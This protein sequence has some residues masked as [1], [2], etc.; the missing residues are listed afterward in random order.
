[1]VRPWITLL[2]LGGLCQAAFAQRPPAQVPASPEAVIERLP[3]GYSALRS[4]TTATQGTRSNPII[5][6][7]QLLQAAGRTGD[8]R[9]AARADVLLAGIPEQRR[10]ARVRKAQAFSAQHR[11]EFALSLQLLDAVI[12]DEPRDPDARLARAQLHL[13]QGRIRAARADCAALAFSVDSQSGTAC[14]AALSLRTGAL[15]NAAT[16]ADL[17]LSQSQLDPS[18]RR[19]MLVM[20]GEIAS[21]AGSAKADEWFN[22]ALALAPDDVRTLAPYARHL[23]QSGRPR[24]T[25]AL[26]SDV[27][28]ADALQLQRAL[29]AH[30]LGAPN[31]R[32]L[33]QSQAR[34]YAVA[35]AVG[36]EPELRDE[37]EL[38]LTLRGQT[39][40]ALALAQRNFE[41]QRDHED[42][43]L[44]QR[45]AAA[46]GQP[47]A[48]EPLHA[49]A[50]EEG[51]ELEVV[52][53]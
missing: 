45:A 33:T 32:E 6:A 21:R 2:L 37:A 47:E 1:M 27:P 49:W 26:L 34:R 20:R 38:L 8:A 29:A 43:D 46:A 36:M 7:E 28:D 17:W 22:Q 51:L 13:V 23:N 41:M 30:A 4:S 31:A 52:T 19:F 16:F 39:A 40:P 42:V 24:E 50:S 35:R 48:L 3:R 10:S 14:V 25:L 11:H 44:L 5:V 15:D 53:P 9:L 18:F 12:R